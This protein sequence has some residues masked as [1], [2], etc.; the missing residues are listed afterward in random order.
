MWWKR[1]KKEVTEFLYKLLVTEGPKGYARK[2]AERMEVPYP[3]LSKYWLGKRR[4]PAALI[5]PLFLATSQDPR[6]AD[7]F[8][9]DGS[10]YQLDRRDD[11]DP[12]T[13]LSRSILLLGKLGGTVN[14][15]YLQATSPESEDGEQ[16]SP[17]EAETL[18]AALQQLVIH[19]ERLRVAFDRQ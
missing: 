2:V 10:D 14:D 4:F 11:A 8:L 9:L 5:K 17:R 15:L 6:V 3:T 7:F 16:I 13:D 18:R 12:P 1:E 19:A